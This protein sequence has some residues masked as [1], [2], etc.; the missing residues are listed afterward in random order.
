MQHHDEAANA[1]TNS[2]INITAVS[3]LKERWK[4][5]HLV[6]G[7]LGRPAVAGSWVRC[8]GAGHAAQ[9]ELMQCGW[10]ELSL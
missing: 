7:V 1:V 4:L 9:T 5:G 3:D 2:Y 10:A 6:V 8:R